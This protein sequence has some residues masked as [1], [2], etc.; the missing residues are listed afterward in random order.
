MGVKLM[1]LLTRVFLA[2]FCFSV[3]FVGNVMADNAETA[4]N[5]ATLFRAARKVVSVNQDHINDASVGDKG[6]SA[7]A[8]TAKTK[9]NYKAA[10]GVD[11]PEGEMYD[12]MIQAVG[13]TMAEN[14]DLIN[15]Q[16]KGFKGFLPAIF[17]KSVADKFS[18]SMAGKA[19][20]KLTAPKELVRNRANRPDKWE[21]GII[22]GKFQSGNWPKDQIYT[23]EGVAVKGKTG[24]RLILPEY[25]GQG[26]LKCHGEPKGGIDI[27][28]GEME[29][30]TL[31]QLG[32][33]I[34]VVLY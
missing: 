32:G 25:Y 19:S 7:D 23:E 6:L 9:E 15:E 26:C 11:L 24:F 21:D 17:A 1:K 31:G 28:G 8:V 27:T 30:G 22:A 10:A 3:I 12:A 16:G 14:Q 13:N 2:V 34:S 29:G 18:S 33:A 5:L 20:I 4:H